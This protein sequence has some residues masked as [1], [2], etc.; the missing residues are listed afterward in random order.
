M[1]NELNIK[2][3]IVRVLFI[4]ILGL[5]LTGCVK[6]ALRFS[7]SFIP[8]MTQTLFEE[9]DPT[10]AQHSL[11]ADL[12]LMEGLL[13]NDSKNKRLLTALCMGFTGYALL[14][15]EDEDPERASRLYLR[16]R[17]YGLRAFGLEMD[18][19]KGLK[20][21]MNGIQKILM[22]VSDAEH[23]ALFWTTM[24]WNAWIALNLHKPEAL[25]QL[26]TAQAFLE[27]VLELKPDYLY[28]AP[29]ILMGALLAGR[30]RF[31]GGSEAKAKE[32]FEKAMALSNRKFF[33]AHYY[34]ARYYAVQVQDKELFFSLLKEVE[35]G[36]ADELRE[37]C[38]INTVMKQKTIK[39]KARSEELFF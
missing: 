10:L 18:P 37:V 15:V 3:Y 13:K 21:G 32:N 12:K 16:A 34:Y 38:L 33:L 36:P 39:L 22:G 29:Y 2:T 17:D 14:F 7:P 4:C 23:E 1:N 24:S 30:P 8:Q 26:E 9:C 28:G 19:L 20:A 5:S 35:G 6:L 27:R 11:P 25:T 31:M